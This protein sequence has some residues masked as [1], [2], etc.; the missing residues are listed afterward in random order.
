VKE[1][2]AN[3]SIS[4]EKRDAL[5]SSGWRD[6]F[7]SEQISHLYDMLDQVEDAEKEF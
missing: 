3:Q 1:L 5:L 7:P 6:L 2:A 4:N